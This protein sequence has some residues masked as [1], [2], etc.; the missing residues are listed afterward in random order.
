MSRP[1][2]LSQAV[3]VEH[4]CRVSPLGLPALALRGPHPMSRV[5]AEH[6]PPVTS[7]LARTHVA[8]ILCNS[9]SFSARNMCDTLCS[10]AAAQRRT[11]LVLRTCS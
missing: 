2:V 3:T 4:I 5:Y 11:F 7:A 6:V 8:Q 9:P 10:A 1:G